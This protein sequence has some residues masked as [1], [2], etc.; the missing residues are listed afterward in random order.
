MARVYE[1]S[2]NK[3]VVLPY[4]NQSGLTVFYSVN[5]LNP[6]DPALSDDNHDAPLVCKSNSNGIWS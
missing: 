4:E 3:D 1:T 6:N 5:K 2:T